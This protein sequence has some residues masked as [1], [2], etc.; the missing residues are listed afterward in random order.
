M[1]VLFYR[2]GKIPETGKYSVMSLTHIFMHLPVAPD[3]TDLVYFPF[4]G[5]FSYLLYGAPR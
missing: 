5:K 1:Q 2:V 3:A 4:L